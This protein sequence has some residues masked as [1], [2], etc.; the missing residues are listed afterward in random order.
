[1][2]HFCTLLLALVAF[3]ATAQE[4][5]PFKVNLSVGYAQPIGAGVSGGLLIAAEPKYGITDNID[6]GLRFEAAIVARGIEVAGNTTTSDVGAFGSYLLTGNY[7]IGKGGFRPFVGL[8]VGLF[9]IGSAG[10]ITVEDGQGAEDVTFVSDTKFGGMI[11]AGFK[12][13]HFVL[14]VEYNAVPTTETQFRNATITSENAYL[15]IKLGFDIGGG[16]K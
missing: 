1:M 7:L 16:R 5:K 13:G 15:G 14:G 8:G 6:L 10:T 11:R 4:F 2:K 9:S 3:T 12:A